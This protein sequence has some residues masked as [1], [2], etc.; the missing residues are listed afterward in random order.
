MATD[1]SITAPGWSGIGIFP[2]ND[3]GKF[4][5][6][7]VADNGATAVPLSYGVTPVRFSLSNMDA[8]V[9]NTSGWSN[10]FGTMVIDKTYQRS[11]T[12]CF[13]GSAANWRGYRRIDLAAAGVTQNQIGKGAYI[14]FSA[15][16]RA[17]DTNNDPGRTGIRFLDTSK[18]VISTILAPWDNTSVTYTR[19]HLV[20]QIPLNAAYVDL[21]L[22]GQYLAGASAGAY[23]DDLE[24][25]YSYK[26]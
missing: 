23:F 3:Y 11:G 24:A 25:G 21:I 22:E 10:E 15:W 1:T 4:F 13:A 5:Q 8:E 18:A 7:A 17:Y 16:Q 12:S 14:S 2:K 9:G 26:Q 6:V 20:E 19:K